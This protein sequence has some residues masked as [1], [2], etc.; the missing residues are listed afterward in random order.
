[1]WRVPEG[2]E[3]RWFECTSTYASHSRHIGLMVSFKKQSGYYYIAAILNNHMEGHRPLTQYVQP[4]DRKGFLIQYCKHLLNVIKQLGP[5]KHSTEMS[6]NLDL[7]L[8]T[9]H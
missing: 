7:Q 1:M 4:M 9:S 8:F 5:L 6:H 3:E 2:S